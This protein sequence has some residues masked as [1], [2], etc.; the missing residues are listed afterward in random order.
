MYFLYRYHFIAPYGCMA[1]YL[2][3]NKHY[4]S[5]FILIYFVVNSYI[6]NKTSNN[7]QQVY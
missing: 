2:I 3:K 7:G 5:L 4:I 6:V 1:Q